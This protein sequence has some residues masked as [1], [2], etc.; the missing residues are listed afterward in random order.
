LGGDAGAAAAEV[1]ASGGL[2]EELPK[3]LKKSESGRSRNRVSLLL[4]PF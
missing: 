1:A 4:S 2:P 3:Y